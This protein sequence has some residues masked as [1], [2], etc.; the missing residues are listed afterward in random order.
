MLTPVVR[1]TWAPRGCTPSLRCWDRRDRVSAISALSLSPT[2]RRV[3][4]YFDLCPRNIRTADVAA[5]LRRL[6]RHLPRGFLVVWDRWSVHRAAARHLRRRGGRRVAFEE[7]P[8]YAP[9]LNPVEQ[10]WSHSKYADLA[11][12]IPDHVDHLAAA[13]IDSLATTATTPDRLRAFIR[14]CGL[15]P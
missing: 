6:Q 1:R 12:F 7:L 8:A 13:V 14:H 5:F 4:L 3:G 15:T 9:E 11:N 10:V 2:R